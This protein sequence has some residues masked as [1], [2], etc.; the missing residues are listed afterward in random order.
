MYFEEIT[1]I[2]LYFFYL[3]IRNMNKDNKVD[4]NK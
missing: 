1:L 3:F 2:T 4:L